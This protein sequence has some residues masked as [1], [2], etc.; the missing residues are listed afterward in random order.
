MSKMINSDPDEMIAKLTADVMNTATPTPQWYQRNDMQK[1]L[2]FEIEDM[3]TV[4]PDKIEWGKNFG[5]LQDGRLY[6]KIHQPIRSDGLFDNMYDIMLVYEPDYLCSPNNTS[7]PAYLLAPNDLDHIHARLNQSDRMPKHLSH[8]LV[9]K[10]GIK[11]L[12][13][14]SGVNNT[15]GTVTARQ[16]L[17]YVIKW[18]FILEFGLLSSQHWEKF[19]YDAI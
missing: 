6:W 14:V 17:I 1:Q 8:I 5:I 2:K 16:S 4:L 18:L 13:T 7:I 12:N 3:K 15:I 11:C 10:Y 19:L 9:D